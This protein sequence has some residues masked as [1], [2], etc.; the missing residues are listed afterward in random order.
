[1]SGE[2]GWRREKREGLGDGFSKKTAFA[3]RDLISA[4]LSP[5][6]CSAS[7]TQN[8]SRHNDAYIYDSHWTARKFT[9]QE[10]RRGST[11]AACTHSLSVCHY[12]PIACEGRRQR[13]HLRGC[14]AL[15]QLCKHVL[16]RG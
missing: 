6:Q 11:G 15:K 3:V 14:A 10:L 2:G 9:V 1:M 12:A 5:P 8:H 4:P 7:S 13:E 16:I